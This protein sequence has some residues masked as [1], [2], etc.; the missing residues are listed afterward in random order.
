MLV[1]LGAGSCGMDSAFRT[2]NPAVRYVAFGDSTTAGPSERDYP[3]FL[4]ELLGEPEEAFANEGEGGETAPEGLERLLGLIDAQIYPNAEVF[5]Y[6]QGGSDVVD[7]IG[8]IDPFL[9]FSPDEEN[10]PFDELLPQKLDDT[11]AALEA[12]IQA[13][14]DAGWRVYIATY[15]PMAPEVT[16]CGALPFDIAFPG[17]ITRADTYIERLNERIRAAASSRGA[18][19]VDIAAYGDALRSDPDHYFNCDHLSASGNEIA[20]RIFYNRVGAPP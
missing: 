5:L 4:R 20:A 13:A 9:L 1:L 7:L 10:Y 15:F 6:W 2:P 11:E 17:Q 18:T 3:D 14:Q 19:L 8:L 16:E 12:G